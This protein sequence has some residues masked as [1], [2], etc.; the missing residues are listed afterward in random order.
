[1]EFILIDNFN[2]NINI[3]SNDDGSG[4]PMTFSSYKEAEEQKDELCQN[5]IIVPLG[6]TMGLIAEAFNCIGMAKFELGEEWDESG[7]EEK[8]GNFLH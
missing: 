3:V 1:M 6:D 8:L 4:E 2:G 5:G 7:I